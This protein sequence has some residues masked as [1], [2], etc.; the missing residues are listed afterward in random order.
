MAKSGHNRVGRG[1]GVALDPVGCGLLRRVL[2]H[3]AITACN[4]LSDP[5]MRGQGCRKG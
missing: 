3:I 2:R 5:H 4:H 1:M